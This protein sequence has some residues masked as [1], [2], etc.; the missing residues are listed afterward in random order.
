MPRKLY[1][2]DGN[3][4]SVPTDD[5]LKDLQTKAEQ[6]GKLSEF[7]KTLKSLRDSLGLKDS[8]DLL[9]AVKEAKESANPNWKATRNKLERLTT[10][11]KTNIKDAE[12]DE[13]GNVKTPANNTIDPNKIQQDMENTARKILNEGTLTQRLAKY[14]ADKREIVKTY[15]NKLSAGEELSAETIEKYMPDAERLAFPNSSPSVR[16]IEGREPNFEDSNRTDYSNTPEGQ[17]AG[18]DMGLRSAQ[19]SGK[20]SK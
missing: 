7:D 8:D 2:E 5:E 18:S 19:Q 11:I 15:F 10:F 12:F 20:E 3:E 14:P 6:V 16:N 13:E 4:V 17:K 9:E 1:D